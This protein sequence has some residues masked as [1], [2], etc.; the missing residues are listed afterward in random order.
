MLKV[1]SILRSL[2]NKKILE[3]EFDRGKKIETAVIDK[4]KN[5]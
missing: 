4:S 1:R 5:S 2:K 3:I